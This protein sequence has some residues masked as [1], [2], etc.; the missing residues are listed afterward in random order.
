MPGMLCISLTPP[1][2]PILQDF[3]KVHLE[4]STLLTWGGLM[5]GLHQTQ[6]KLR[7]LSTDD[8]MIPFI[9]WKEGE[10]PLKQIQSFSLK[11][12]REKQFLV[13]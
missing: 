9:L 2:L 5:D 12:G 6:E 10:T 1:S 3:A 7:K 11:S 8:R 13:S 4:N